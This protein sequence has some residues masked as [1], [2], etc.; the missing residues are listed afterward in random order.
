MP[1]RASDAAADWLGI[2]FGTCYSSAAR[3]VDG[4]PVAVKEPVG[5]GYSVPSSVMLTSANGREE[6][7]VGV[8]AERQRLGQ[9]HRFTSEFKRVL[10]QREQVELGGRQFPVG[11]LVA[12]VVG[13]LRREAEK[14]GARELPNAV[15]TVPVSYE[16]HLRDLMVEAARKAGFARVELLEEPVAALIDYAHD[17]D[18]A[19][20]AN[21]LV[22]V[23]DLGGG[24]FDCALVSVDGGGHEVLGYDGIEDVGGANFDRAVEGDVARQAGDIL[25]RSLEA[26]TSDVETERIAALRDEQIAREKCRELKHDLSSL[27]TAR[28]DIFL[29]GGLVEYELTRER[30]AE[31]IDVHIRRTL[32]CCKRVL[33][34]AGRAWEDVDGIL[35]VGGSCRLPFVEQAVA[36]ESGRPIWHVDDPELTVCEGAAL[37]AAALAIPAVRDLVVD[38]GGAGD[39]TSI[40]AAV[41]ASGARGEGGGQAWSLRGIR[42]ARQGGRARR[43]RVQDEDRAAREDRPGAHRHRPATAPAST[44]SAWALGRRSSS[45]SQKGASATI[46]SCDIVVRQGEGVTVAGGAVCVLRGNHIFDPAADAP[47][48]AEGTTAPDRLKTI[49]VR[50]RDGSNVTLEHNDLKGL[51]SAGVQASGEDTVLVCRGDRF[52]QMGASA[53]VVAGADATLERCDIARTTSSAVVARGDGTELTMQGS[54]IKD[55]DEGAG[56]LL[57]KAAAGRIE[58]CEISDADEGVSIDGAVADVLGCTLRGNGV[59]VMRQRARAFAWT[60]TTSSRVTRGG[61]RGQDKGTSLELVRNR[62]TDGEH[63]GRGSA[64]SAVLVIA[65][66]TIRANAGCG[67]TVLER[68]SADIHDCRV[69]ASGSVRHRLRNWSDGDDRS[70]TTCSRT[71]CPASQLTDSKTAPTVRGN[72]IHRNGQDGVLARLAPAASLR[73]TGSTTTSSTAST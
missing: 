45:R 40:G 73:T 5:R 43:R 38:A 69:E 62:I 3:I 21:G 53:V 12:E 29:S 60:T 37:H 46:E 66:T 71:A 11:D 26:R 7:V 52:E 17:A 20:A 39:H 8:A 55:V 6:L 51:F 56:V 15:V 42:D 30:L 19:A 50:A 61:V 44:G 41:D 10:G 13:Y 25:A 57:T 27:E 36:S 24:T 70:A 58:Q 9:P 32:E 68:S 28:T 64:S 34:E 31:M 48:P 63:G 23:Y 67:V 54:R 49:G 35:M 4:Q 72:E 59:G 33:E 47:V 2:D 14:A 1:G 18:G 22:L 16:Q 65:E